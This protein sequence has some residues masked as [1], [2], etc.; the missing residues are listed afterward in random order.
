MRAR[1]SD[2]SFEAGSRR[3]TRAWRAIATALGVAAALVTA[4]LAV[5]PFFARP[6][7]LPKEYI[8]RFSYQE[9]FA[10]SHFTQDWRRLTGNPEQE[11]APNLLLVGDSYVY[12]SQ[13][14]DEATVG[15]V[16]ERLARDGGMPVNVRVYGYPAEGVAQYAGVAPEL[17][18]RWDPK[19]VVVAINPS[20]IAPTELV[21]G[22]WWRLQ[23]APDLSVE[24]T[25]VEGAS[26]RGSSGRETRRTLLKRLEAFLSKFRIYDMVYWRTQE[27]LKTVPGQEPEAPPVAVP[28]EAVA[29]IT[30]RMLKEAYGDRLVVAYLSLVLPGSLRESELPEDERRLVE[31][32]EREGVPCVAL[33]DALVADRRANPR[34]SR[35]FLNSWPGRGHFNELGHAIA[36]REIFEAVSALEKADTSR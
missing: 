13:V 21:R 7:G 11:N 19:W 6:R 30:V 29:P 31:E 10:Y 17:L 16:L 23:V 34:F 25:R 2:S 14:E 35:G 20:D 8:E 18:N 33:R 4:E 28:E 26:P 22:R 27:L 1:H 3:P 32:C 15:S 5:A 36:A 9:G 24:L 12:G